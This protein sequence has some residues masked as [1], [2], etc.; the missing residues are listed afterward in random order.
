MRCK[1]NAFLAY[2]GAVYIMACIMYLALTRD[3]G[4]PF[5]DSLTKEQVAIKEKSKTDRRRAF[6][7][8]VAISVIAITVMRPFGECMC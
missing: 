6:I 3:L 8:G 5:L 2:S 4:T 7:I 1:V